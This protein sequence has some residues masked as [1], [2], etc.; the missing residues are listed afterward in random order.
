METEKLR[1]KLELSQSQSASLRLRQAL[2]L[3]PSQRQRPRIR[4][5]QQREP[6]QQ[7]V[8]NSIV[9]RNAVAAIENT[10]L[11]RALSQVDHLETRN[12][13]IGAEKSQLEA[14]LDAERKVWHEQFTEFSTQVDQMESEA[15]NAEKRHAE[16]LVQS[17]ADAR[18]NHNQLAEALSSHSHELKRALQ[19]SVEYAVTIE[20]NNAELRTKL[21]SAAHELRTQRTDRH[22]ELLVHRDTISSFAPRLRNAAI[23]LLQKQHKVQ[24]MLTLKQALFAF[25]HAH[26]TAR[27][28]QELASSEALVNYAGEAQK[29]VLKQSQRMEQ[30]MDR[31]QQ[32]KLH[33]LTGGLK[34]LRR[35]MRHREQLSLSMSFAAMQCRMKADHIARREKLQYELQVE[36]EKRQKEI[37]TQDLVRSFEIKI[38]EVTEDGKYQRQLST[39]KIEGM[40]TAFED[41]LQDMRVEREELMEHHEQQIQQVKQLHNVER[42]NL[43]EEQEELLE[44]FQSDIKVITEEHDHELQEL[45]CEMEACRQAHNIEMLEIGQARQK[46]TNAALEAH[47]REMSHLMEAHQSDSAAVKD[48]HRRARLCLSVSRR[49]F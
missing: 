7:N 21:E 43:H 26:M 32:I 36:M 44:Q 2:G 39:A 33:V 46:E 25:R 5:P 35:A 47:E 40:E 45:R 8:N 48:K 12:A 27:H 34:A 30:I 13:I 18:R 49:S 42:Q 38:G 4:V 20:E 22:K 1:L 24:S 37:E 19:E 14:Q 6:P 9:S 11:Q 31:V 17:A 10:E 23:C 16:A 15:S 29:Q 28:L 41:A 3:P